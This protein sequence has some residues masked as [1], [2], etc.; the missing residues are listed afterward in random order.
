MWSFAY[1]ATL[2]W[3][4]AVAKV[5]NWS[6]HWW[7]ALFIAPPPVNKSAGGFVWFENKSQ[8]LPKWSS[9]FAAALSPHAFLLTKQ[10][11]RAPL[12]GR[13]HWNIHR[14]I[15]PFVTGARAKLRMQRLVARQE[16]NE[17]C[18][19]WPSLTG[20]GIVISG[21]CRWTEYWSEWQCP[22]FPP[23]LGGYHRRESIP[24]G[25]EGF[26][27]GWIHQHTS[28][29]RAEPCPSH[30]ELQENVW[31]WTHALEIRCVDLM[32]RG[33]GAHLSSV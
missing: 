16:G 10:R 15:D 28:A 11:Q 5:T 25:G 32:S 20:N 22:A 26:L 27:C 23:S 7:D 33:I 1:L 30:P 4:G 21:W 6:K 2:A 8:F 29:G 3:L 13:E 18:P 24:I 19:L 9:Q 12:L 17:P 31:P 14:F